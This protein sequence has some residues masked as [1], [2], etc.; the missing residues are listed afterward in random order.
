MMNLLSPQ[1]KYDQNRY[2]TILILLILIIFI[3]AC[4]KNSDS[5]NLE[6]SLKQIESTQISP[7][8]QNDD[9]QTLKSEKIIQASLYNNVFRFSFKIPHIYSVE[10]IPEIEAINI[11]NPSL[12]GPNIREKSQIFVRYFQANQFLTLKTVN[13]LNRKDT[14]L[15]NH[16]AVQYEIE[17]KPGIADFSQQPSWRNKKHKLTDIRLSNT[18]PSFFYVF[19]YNPLLLEENFENF[20]ESMIFYNDAESFIIPLN[21]GKKRITKKPFALKVGPGDSPV[22][23]EKF[24]GYHT[25]VDFEIFENEIEQNIA[26]KAFCGGK[27]QKKESASGYGGV[28]I[29]ECLIKDQII[30]IIYGHLKL[31]SIKKK[32]GD[33][34]YPGQEIGILG[35]NVSPETDFERKHLHFG[36][37]KG[38][39]P[40]IRGYVDSQNELQNWLDPNQFIK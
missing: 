5:S 11:Y 16:S 13:I 22:Q 19:A 39:K 9:S 33:Y 1:K 37:Y 23:N 6:N 34:L 8:K 4:K 35:K 30:S 32:P 17:K 2:H 10:Y 18:N 36:I 31:D 28:V 26:V 7:Q 14:T 20:L 38:Q 40:D 25:G 24:S 21:E 15:K 3:S 27:L 29:Q 12:D